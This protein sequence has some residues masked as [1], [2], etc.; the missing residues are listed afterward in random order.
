MI[1]KQTKNKNDKDRNLR[2]KIY[3]LD[4]QYQTQRYIASLIV[5]IIPG[6]NN[7]IKIGMIKY[8]IE[9]IE[10]IYKNSLKYCYYP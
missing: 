3:H 7:Q 6:Y 5:Y 8:Y 1:N 9:D 4:L 2:T 10:M